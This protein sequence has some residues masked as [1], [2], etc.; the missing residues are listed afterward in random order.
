[1]QM[2]MGGGGRWGVGYAGMGMEQRK[3]KY[4]EA[5]ANNYVVL[6]VPA[7]WISMYSSNVQLFSL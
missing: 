7:W 2:R 6:K 3:I 4:I 5:K 1:M